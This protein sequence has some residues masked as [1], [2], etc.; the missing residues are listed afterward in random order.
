M[1]NIAAA[2]QSLANRLLANPGAE[3][4]GCQ[5]DVSEAQKRL[6]DLAANLSWQKRRWTVGTISSPL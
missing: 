1:H 6:D 2:L 5:R 4:E 3:V